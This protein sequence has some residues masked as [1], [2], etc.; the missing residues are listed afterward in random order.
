MLCLPARLLLPS[1][2]PGGDLYHDLR[3]AVDHWEVKSAT[4]SK[5]QYAAVGES[6]ILPVRVHA[7]TNVQLPLHPFVLLPTFLCSHSPS[8]ILVQAG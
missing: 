8:Q 5:S 1:S 2:I 3:G 7:G 4:S 6:C